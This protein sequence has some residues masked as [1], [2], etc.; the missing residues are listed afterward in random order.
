MVRV[1]AELVIWA[2]PVTTFPPSGFAYAAPKGNA[3]AYA[4]KNACGSVGRVTN[5]ALF[6]IVIDFP[7][8]IRCM[9]LGNIAK[10]DEEGVNE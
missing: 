7:R 9:Y 1:E 5:V 6:T 8:A 10:N 2:V 3:S 4:T